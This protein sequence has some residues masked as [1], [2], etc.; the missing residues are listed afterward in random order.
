MHG[1]DWFGL[2]LQLYPPSEI[3]LPEGFPTARNVEVM[4]LFGFNFTVPKQFDLVVLMMT[5]CP[6][7]CELEIV[8]KEFIP[9]DEI[10]AAAKSSIDPEYGFTD[11][12]LGTLKTVKM[13]S[14]RALRLE[15][16]FVKAIL[17]NS[18]ALEKLVIQESPYIDALM[19]SKTARKMLCF[20]RA[21]PK[22]QVVFLEY[23]SP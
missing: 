23:K 19:A 5:K 1:W 10:E 4:K 12:D 16:L 15:I 9:R 22:A 17:L 20:P 6:N 21:S 14:F 8:P 7:L 3:N 11:Q 13:Q 2:H 18:P